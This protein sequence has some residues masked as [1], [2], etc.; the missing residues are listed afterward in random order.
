LEVAIS[1]DGSTIAV[2]SSQSREVYIFDLTATG[3]V[4]SAE[5]AAPAAQARLGFGWSLSLSGDGS[6]LAIG[7]ASGY[8]NYYTRQQNG[9]WKLAQTLTGPGFYGFG[10]HVALSSDASTLLIGEAAGGSTTAGEVL[11]YT[12]SDGKWKKSATLK[13]S[14]GE[15]DNAFGNTMAVSADGSRAVIASPSANSGQGAM[16]VFSRN[17]KG[18]WHQAAELTA[19]DGKP[20]DHLGYNGWTNYCTIGLTGNGTTA[21]IGAPDAGAAYAFS[22]SSSK[23]WSQAAEFRGLGDEGTS[24]G[25]SANG[26]AIVV[27][28]PGTTSGSGVVHIYTPGSTGWTLAQTLVD[29]GM[30]G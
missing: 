15:K 28:A 7:G 3:W 10:D 17:G 8:A 29:P 19:S 21:V 20:G 14:N 22:A 9:S 12:Q 2:D 6:G 13:A 27:S 30:T 26:S 24:D 4:Q 5:L 18:R 25:I 16:Y 23:S 1:G 11:A